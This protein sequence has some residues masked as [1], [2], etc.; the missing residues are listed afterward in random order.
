MS[1]HTRQWNQQ[2]YEN[3]LREGRGQGEGMDYKP[4]VRIQDFASKG[5]VSRVYS[6]KTG[7]VHHLLS[8]NEKYYFYLLEWSDQVLDIREQFPL[9]DIQTAMAIADSAGIKYP[10]DNVSGFPYVLSCDFFITTRNGMKAR[11]IKQSSELNRT[12]VV[13]KLEIERRYWKRQ[14]IDWKLVTENEIRQPLAKNLEWLH[15]AY[16]YEDIPTCLRNELFARLKEQY[17]GTELPVVTITDAADYTYGFAH[18][19]C[20]SLFKY[21]VWTKYISFD[22]SH[23]LNF[24][25][26]RI[27]ARANKEKPVLC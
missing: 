3:Y 20:L 9:A 21:L 24:G 19:T 13:E 11:T 22:L 2:K 6:P 12:R 15:S 5:T 14:N 8:N 1:K 17:D 27:K 10:T 18:G 25:M 4:W 7:R 26:K 16:V 23:E